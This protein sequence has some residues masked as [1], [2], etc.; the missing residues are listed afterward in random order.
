MKI[1]FF[2]TGEF[3]VGPLERL[4]KDGVDVT[5]IVSQPDKPKGRHLKLTAPAVKTAGD[6][7]K[8]P[9]LQPKRLSDKNFISHL[10]NLNP[11]IF[12]VITYGK[13]LKTE[14]LSI[15]KIF[16]INLHA[17]LLPKY[18]GAAPI[19]WA[20]LNGDVETGV[21][22]IKMNEKMDAGEIITQ[23]R[24]KIET[25]DDY[26]SLSKK[27]SF[28]GENLLAQ[29]VKKIQSSDFMLTKQDDKLATLAPKLTKKDGLINWNDTAVNIHN[30]I[31]GLYGWPGCFT[32]LKD[33]IIKIHKSQ[34]KDISIPKNIQPGQII[35]IDTDSI[36]VATKIGIL[37]IK[38]LQ[39]ES[40]KR[41]KVPQFVAG[42][43]IK[44]G[45]R[46]G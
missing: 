13:I 12:V 32:H 42:H 37:A 45:D 35:E 18:R 26:Y 44:A 5:T 22:I 46:L 2:G 4:I 14:I 34:I 21:T 33:K 29:T 3:A 23:G 39:P 15:P 24:V 38:E 25:S 19:N 10:K 11:D 9:V 16:S 6:K 27:L 7:L 1:V 20:I 43:D 30:K 36:Y 41:M 17:S 31:R 28:E 40:S 8:I